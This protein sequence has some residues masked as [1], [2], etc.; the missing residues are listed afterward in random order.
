MQKW[1]VECQKQSN[2]TMCKSLEEQQHSKCVLMPLGYYS[3]LLWH[4]TMHSA[5]PCTHCIHTLANKCCTYPLYCIML[6]KVG[7][8]L[9]LI[10]QSCSYWKFMMHSQSHLNVWNS[11]VEGTWPVDQP[12]VSVDQ[13]LV[14]QSDKSFCHCPAQF[15]QIN[16]NPS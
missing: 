4:N 2:I 7:P 16:G 1:E 10:Y 13:S 6:I 14:M 3:K 8:R 5:H 15:L 11:W 9:L 12:T